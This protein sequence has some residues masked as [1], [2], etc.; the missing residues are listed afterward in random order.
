KVPAE[1]GSSPPVRLVDHARMPVVSPDN[2]FVVF[3]Y[4]PEGRS[5]EFVIMPFQGGGSFRP[6]PIPVREW[7][8]LQWTPDSS[9]LTYVDVANGVSNIWRYDL[10]SNTKKQLTDFKTDQIFAYAWS[11]DFKQLA[12][13]RG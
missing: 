5:P 3:R 10:A 7:Q 1:G 12:S 11:P 13:M 8:R 2:Q 9:A 4:Y 6:L